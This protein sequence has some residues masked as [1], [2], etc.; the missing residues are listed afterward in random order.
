MYV[1]FELSRNIFLYSRFDLRAI[2]M[3]ML[4]RWQSYCLSLVM[5]PFFSFLFQRFAILKLYILYCVE[6]NMQWKHRIHCLSV[7][8]WSFSSSTLQNGCNQA[9]FSLTL[10]NCWGNWL[11]FPQ[12]VTYHGKAYCFIN[13]HVEGSSYYM[14]EAFINRGTRP[15]VYSHAIAALWG[16]TRA[17]Y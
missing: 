10:A 5:F 2:W 4:R 15:R 7:I 9:W 8:F 16:R 12:H 3:F 1:W 17:Q 13:L 11:L 14:Y 6:I